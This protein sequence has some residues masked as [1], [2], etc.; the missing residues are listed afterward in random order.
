MIK[1]VLRLIFL[2]GIYIFK[3][4]NNLS[5][6]LFFFSRY[7]LVIEICYSRNLW[8][9]GYTLFFYD[10]YSYYLV[11]LS[12]WICGCILIINN[13][14]KFIELIILILLISLI[15][16]FFSLNLIIFYLIFEVSLL[17]IFFIILYRGYSF[18]RYEAIIY[19]LIYTIVSSIPFLWLLFLIYLNY[20]RLIIIILRFLI[21]EFE[22]ILFLLCL[23]GFIVKLPIFLFHIWL[24][25][26]HVEAPVYGSIIL[27]GVLLKLGRYGILRIIQLFYIN[28]K[29]FRYIIITLGVVGGLLIRFVCLIQ[30]DI[31]ILVAYSSVVHISLLIRGIITISKTGLIGGLI[32]ILAHGLCSSGLFYIVNINYECFG[33]RLL[34][35]NKG[36]IN[37]YP[38]LRLFWFLLCSSNLSAPLRLNLFRE[39]FLLIRLVRWRIILIIFLIFI[40]FLRAAYSLYLFRISQHGELVLNQLKFKNI[41]VLN[42]FI[43]IIHW[44]PL[45]LLFLRLE[46]FIV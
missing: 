11:I 12:L 40:C 21:I 10:F 30:I 16:C 6:V 29:D 19:I 22:W 25:K 28:I 31:K 27:A 42:Y 3:K 4:K 35:L 37:I 15:L 46:L 44:L 2:M 36:S 33:R 5:L 34:Y 32:I 13:I 9:G 43:L 23:F 26:A 8:I 14:R 17:P 38:S 24:P 18:E 20:E 41:T 1:L 7:I 45:N 39:F